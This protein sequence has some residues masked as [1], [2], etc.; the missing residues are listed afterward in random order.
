MSIFSLYL[1]IGV[2]PDVVYV[3]LVAVT[4]SPSTK[5]FCILPQVQAIDTV[6]LNI[7]LSFFSTAKSP[8]T[9]LAFVPCVSIIRCISFVSLLLMPHQSSSHLLSISLKCTCFSLLLL[10]VQSVSIIVC[11]D[12]SF[13]CWQFPWPCF[14][15]CIGPSG[16]D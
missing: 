1:Y 5:P 4:V 11:I 3:V 12:T 10:L 16:L 7:S 14:I 13:D 6:P 9:V 15:C 8:P 2:L